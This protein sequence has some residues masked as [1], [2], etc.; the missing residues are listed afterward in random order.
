MKKSTHA[1]SHNTVFQLLSEM[2]LRR[3]LS[4]KE[5]DIRDAEIKI[6]NE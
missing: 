3:M 6:E 5:M 1:V 4:K 2:R